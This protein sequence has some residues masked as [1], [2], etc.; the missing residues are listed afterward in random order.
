[1]SA[2]D[3]QLLDAHAGADGR[4]LARLYASAAGQA[5]GEAQAFYLTHAWIFA[6][7]AGVP[8]AEALGASLRELGRA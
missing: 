2:L 7:E 4:A 5:R 3:R 1:M 8:E 6:L